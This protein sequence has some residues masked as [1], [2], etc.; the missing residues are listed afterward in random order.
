MEAWF[1][2]DHKRSSNPSRGQQVDSRCGSSPQSLYSSNWDDDEMVTRWLEKERTR[3]IHERI[4]TL[5]NQTIRNQVLD[6]GSKSPDMVAEGVLDLLA[7]L[8]GEAKER[9]ISTL[10]R[11]VLLQSQPQADYYEE[12]QLVEF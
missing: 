6:L 3:S 5:S 1:G 2:Q 7:K 11:G 8:P 12:D 9:M 4:E 10:K